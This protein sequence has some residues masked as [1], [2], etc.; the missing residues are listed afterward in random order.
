MIIVKKK[1]FFSVNKQANMLERHT[2]IQDTQPPL[3]CGCY[4]REL[5]SLFC[6]NAKPFGFLVRKLQNGGKIRAGVRYTVLR[7]LAVSSKCL[8]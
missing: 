8:D 4:I 6:F 1:N 5:I 3:N 7:A 2:H